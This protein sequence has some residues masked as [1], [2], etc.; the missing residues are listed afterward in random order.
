MNKQKEAGYYAF[1]GETINF[2]IKQTECPRITE[3][4]LK[5]HDKVKGVVRFETNLMLTYASIL[6]EGPNTEEH[7]RIK[8]NMKT[9][10]QMCRAMPHLT[11]Y[12]HEEISK[13]AILFEL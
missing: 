9:L 11:G 12:V 13:S 1:L 5:A 6:Q 4:M 8:K 3:R 2:F 10:S 7:A